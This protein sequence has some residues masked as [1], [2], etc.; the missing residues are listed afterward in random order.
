[1]V[2]DVDFY[3]SKIKYLVKKKK[4]NYVSKKGK[5]CD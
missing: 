3:N 4:T 1:M 5:S 2:E